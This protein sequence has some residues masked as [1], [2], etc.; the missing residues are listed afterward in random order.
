MGQGSAGMVT[1][2]YIHHGLSFLLN[3][4]SVVNNPSANAGDVSLISER[5]DPLEKEMATHTSTLAWE[6]PWTE[7][8]GGATVYGVTKGHDFA[9]KQPPPPPGSMRD[10]SSLTG[11]RTHTT[12]SERAGS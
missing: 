6:I 12:C 3:H 4:G 11:D 1:R 9:T 8:P 7:E 5:E 10:L 2:L